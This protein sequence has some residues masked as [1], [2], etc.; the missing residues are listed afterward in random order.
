MSVQTQCCFLGAFTYI[1]TIHILLWLYCCPALL[2]VHREYKGTS[3]RTYR[4]RGG[5]LNP[6]ASDYSNWAESLRKCATVE[7]RVAKPTLVKTELKTREP[8][9]TPASAVWVCFTCMCAW[10]VKLCLTFNLNHLFSHNASLAHTQRINRS[11]EMSQEVIVSQTES[12]THNPEASL[13][14]A[15]PSDA[16]SPQ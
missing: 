15:F 8:E 12:I 3:P 5:N 9:V 7:F 13:V 11:P 1:C 6:S 2:H 4:S 10:L 16:L 14:E